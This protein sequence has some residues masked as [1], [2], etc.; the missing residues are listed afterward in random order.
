[1][2][3][4]NYAYYSLSM[5]S[6]ITI[7]YMTDTIAYTIENFVF[8]YLGMCIPLQI[9]KANFIHVGLGLGALLV[10]R[11]LSVFIISFIVNKFNKKRI[12]FTHQLLLSYAGLRGAVAFYLVY[13][14]TFMKVRPQLTF[15]KEMKG[16]KPSATCK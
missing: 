14:M 12:P 8:A 5:Y 2:M 3:M 11:Y 9:D 1:M 4:R 7:E 6:R 10:S 13:N 15:R 16:R